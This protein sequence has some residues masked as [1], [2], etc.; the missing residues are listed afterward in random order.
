MN[1]QTPETDALEAKIF[2]STNL[3]ERISGSHWQTT[4]ITLRDFARKLELERNEARADAAVMRKALEHAHTAINYAVTSGFEDTIKTIIS[5]ALSTNAGRELLAEV[6]RLR[7]EN[8]KLAI[9][10]GS[11][12]LP[13]HIAAE[14]E[15]LR[16]MAANLT[17]HS[18][19]STACAGCGKVKHTPLRQDEMGGY[20]CL[21]CIDKELTTLRRKVE[22]AK[23]MAEALKHYSTATLTYGTDIGGKARAALTAWQEANK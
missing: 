7:D 6:E 9:K 19:Q 5:A 13:P 8:R 15:S 17:Y 14:L 4:C 2:D 16:N 22:A 21:T 12:T 23:G 20:V 18:A 1:T 10:A 11:Y 3:T